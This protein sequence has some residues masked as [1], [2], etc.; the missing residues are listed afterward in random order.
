MKDF[1]AETSFP[2]RDST[3]LNES[4]SSCIL[5]KSLFLRFIGLLCC[6]VVSAA[7]LACCYWNFCFINKPEV[8]C[9]H[10]KLLAWKLNSQPV[11]AC[12]HRW[13][14]KVSSKDGS[15]GV[16]FQRSM[17]L[18][19]MVWMEAENFLE[20]SRQVWREY[21]AIRTLDSRSWHWTPSV[22][23]WVSLCDGS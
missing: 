14:L 18:F 5:F 3:V 19:M 17:H 1:K 22:L 4:Q 13:A 6:W 10:S 11:C 20:C 15:E 8:F 21:C 7:I 9:W 2:N 16:Q 23:Q 12:I